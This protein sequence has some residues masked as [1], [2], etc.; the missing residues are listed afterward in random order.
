MINVYLDSDK[1]Q[2]F[3]IPNINDIDDLSE[4]MQ[5]CKRNF[6]LPPDFDE[7]HYG[8]KTK[9]QHIL[10]ADIGDLVKSKRN[11]GYSENL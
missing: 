1:S 6:Q 4:I 11:T 8:F 5:L 2:K 3:Q 7:S 9:Q 10:L